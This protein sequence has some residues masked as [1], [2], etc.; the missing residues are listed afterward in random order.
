MSSA[1]GIIGSLIGSGLDFF[2][3]QQRNEVNRQISREQ[4][5]F[6]ERMSNTAYVRAMADMRNAGLNPILAYQRGGASTPAGASI[7]AINPFQ[8]ASNTASKALQSVERSKNLDLLD[9][10][11]RKSRSESNLNDQNNRLSFMNEQKTK[12]DIETAKNNAASSSSAA[13]VARTEEERANIVRK[14]MGTP[15]GRKLV[16]TDFVGQSLNPAASSAKSL[17]QTLRP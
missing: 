12:H 10:N 7:P 2:G 14:F 16:I 1:F 3:G 9:E 4:M 11:T 5:A 15:H 8:D 17:G 13:S 6:Q